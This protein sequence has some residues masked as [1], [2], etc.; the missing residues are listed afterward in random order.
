MSYCNVDYIAERL[1]KMAQIGKSMPPS[2][3]GAKFTVPVISPDGGARIGKLLPGR[4]LYLDSDL[5][6][7]GITKKLPFVFERTPTMRLLEKLKSERGAIA[8]VALVV[9]VSAYSRE[10]LYSVLPG[11]VLGTLTTYDSI[12]T[13]RAGGNATDY[14]ISKL[15][16]TTAT[17]NW[18]ALFDVGGLPVAGAYSGTPGAAFNSGTT[19]A[20]SFSIPDTSGSNKCYLL[21]FGFTAAQQINMALLVDLLVAVGSLTVAGTGATV[22]S[23][24]LTRYT[25]GAGVMMTFEVTTALGASASNLTVSYT[26]QAGTSGQSTGAIALTT[27]A[28]VGRLQPVGLGPFMQL[29]SGDF[30]VQ[31]VATATTSANMGAGALALN[32]Y[33]P[34]A[35]VPGVAANVYVE[36][37]SN[38][39]I[40]GISQIQQDSGNN[41]G[42]LT[43]YVMP[44]GTSTGVLTAFFRTVQG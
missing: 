10:F 12:I 34:L 35:L 5:R 26:N 13:A 20:L 7:V 11:F 16:I 9:A 17:N 30:G 22:N 3:D 21:T 6:S 28:I 31:A 41:V 44:S 24:A 39:Q 8:A 1:M 4:G 18:S 15:S 38:I 19:G 32:L 29:A 42:C 27:S 40:D 2:W 25:S 23:A 37:D 14:A 36:R 43:L 33:A